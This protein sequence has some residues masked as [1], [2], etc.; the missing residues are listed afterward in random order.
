MKDFFGN[1]VPKFTIENWVKDNYE[2]SKYELDKLVIPN[3]VKV[4]WLPENV[5]RNNQLIEMWEI[6]TKFWKTQ[7]DNLNTK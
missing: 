5:D 1:E 2:S 7:L 4:Q 6:K 3:D